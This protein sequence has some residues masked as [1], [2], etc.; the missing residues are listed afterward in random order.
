MRLSFWESIARRRVR[1][2][3]PEDVRSRLAALRVRSR[4]RAREDRSITSGLF[5][6]TRLVAVDLETTG[7]DMHSDRIISI[8][9][10]AVAAHAA[11]PRQLRG[12]GAPAA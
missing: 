9:G 6:L 8:G 3:L 7:P 12:R 5:A 10:V 11:P 2:A 4:L 1:G